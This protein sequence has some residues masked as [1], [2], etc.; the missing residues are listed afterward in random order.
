L[1]WYKADAIPALNDGGAVNSWDDSSGG[2][3][4]MTADYAGIPTYRINVINGLPVVRFLIGD[5]MGTWPNFPFNIPQ[6]WTYTVVGYAQDH[7]VNRGFMSTSTCGNVLLVWVTGGNAHVYD[8]TSGLG[9]NDSADR[10]GAFHIFTAIVN[11]ASSSIFVD[12]TPVASGTLDT[13]G[14]VHLFLG[15]S[16]I[17]I[18]GG[19]VDIAEA[20][21]YNHALSPAE[22]QSLESGLSTKYAL[23]LGAASRPGFFFFFR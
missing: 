19:G 21:L 5:G 6:P 3:H 16:D 4:T 13:T 12:G 22:R 10:S 2:G 7:T 15:Q 11:G 18:I 9:V 17:N 14:L 8:Y 1:A 20:T 23:P